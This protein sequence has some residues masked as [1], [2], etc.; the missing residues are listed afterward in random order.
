MRPEQNPDFPGHQAP[1]MQNGA[2]GGLKVCGELPTG[3]EHAVRN[4]RR[5]RLQR[6]SHSTPT[7]PQTM[8]LVR[9]GRDRRRS[10]ASRCRWSRPE[11]RVRQRGLHP[12]DALQ[13]VP[14]TRHLGG[15]R[16]A[17]TGVR[18]PSSVDRNIRTSFFG[19]HSAGYFP[20]LCRKYANF[21]NEAAGKTLISSLHIGSELSLFLF[22]FF[23]R[24]DL[25]Y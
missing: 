6:E 25:H 14:L 10:Q 9:H 7:A 15:D 24:R 16:N 11:D 19:P 23:L 20:P 22:F 13:T 1:G 17:G 4:G 5:H 18:C 12:C 2:P 8:S 3:Y 21:R